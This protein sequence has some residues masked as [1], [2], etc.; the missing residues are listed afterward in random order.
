MGREGSAAGLGGSRGLVIGGD[1]LGRRCDVGVGF[2]LD[3]LF[4]SSSVL[5][6]ALHMPLLQAL[7]KPLDQPCLTHD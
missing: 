1:G 4:F 7:D 2:V 6:H 3:L 5:H